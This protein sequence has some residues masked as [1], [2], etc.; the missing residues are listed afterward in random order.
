MR[1]P[2]TPAPRYVVAVAAVV[3]GAAIRLALDPLWGDGLPFIS[4]FGAVIVAG[5]FGGLGPGLLA[6]AL[7]ALCADFFWISPRWAFGVSTV[8]DLAGLA[9]FVVVGVVISIV[10]ETPRRAMARLDAL[11]DASPFALGFHDRDLR[12]IRVNR[13]LAQINNRPAEDHPGHTVRD[14]LGARAA[15]V[16][17]PVLRRVVET[18]QSVHVPSMHVALEHQPPR[19]YSVTYAPVRS[20][21]GR[22]VGASV[23][24]VDI[25]ERQQTE[26]ALAHER[27][28]LQTIIDSIPVMITLYD[29]DTRVL[30]LNRE[31]ERVTGWT[32]AEAS[33]V[34]FME[35]CYPDPAYRAMVREYMD[36]L[37]PGWR[38]IEMTTKSGRVLHTS[39]SNVRLSDHSLVGIGLDVTD[40][41][42]YEADLD[43]ARA[44]AET[45]SRMKDE[46][47]AMLGHEL[48][49]PLSA[50]SAAIAVLQ[51]LGPDDEPASSARAVIHRQ[52][53]HL[54]R[55]MDDLLDVGRVMTG[56][57]ALDRQPLRLRELTERAVATMRATGRTERHTVTV[58]GGDAWIHADTTRIE[59]IV[60][61]LLTNALKYTPAG[62]A[63]TLTVDVDGPEAVLRVSD[64]GRGIE[65]DLLPRIFDLFVQGDQR[66]ERAQ[67]GLGIGLTL[68]RRLAELHGGRV[69]VASRGTDSGATFTVRLPRASPPS[70]APAPRV[71]R[72]APKQ[73]IMIVED[74]ADAR[75]ML[76]T[77]LELDGHLV[78]EAG[79]GAAGAEAIVSLRPDIAFVDIGLPGVDG[80][81]V[82]RRLRADARASRTKLV[83]LTGYGQPEDARRARKAGFDLHLIKPVDPAILGTVLAR[84]AGPS[85]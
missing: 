29:P 47:I 36:V 70:P 24:V 73:R 66:S 68:V 7:G 57:I 5:W 49:N 51:R 58:T 46:F 75:D 54:A 23:G 59:Q 11:L 43:R 30:R 37:Q 83:A 38:D 78:Y 82:A 31:F 61:N 19:W 69:E 1:R 53:G 71:S 62:G 60:S 48:R 35:A 8:G 4:L 32:A 72:D 56:K 76:R 64:T 45:A 79:D 85:G 80:Y 44:A 20:V 2:G 77:M 15:E 25:T 55:L 3:V 9:G 27:E 34:D 17:E 63:I 26:S 6:T 42:R 28:L 21:T 67:G 16:V 41:K 84:L 10:F 52:A 40:R 33:T 50:I 22:V 39:W 18:G 12:Y 65:P 13:Q 81:E 74:N 14:I